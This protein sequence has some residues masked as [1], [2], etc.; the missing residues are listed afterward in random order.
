MIYTP[1]HEE[2]FEQDEDELFDIEEFLNQYK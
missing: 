1:T 2:F